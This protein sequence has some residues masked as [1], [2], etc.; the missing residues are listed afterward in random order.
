LIKEFNYVE[1]E[2]VDS[3]ISEE[4]KNMVREI[5]LHTKIEDFVDA[6]TFMNNL[7]KEL[8]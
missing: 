8:I 2:E 4:H 7:E 3:T 1:I 5:K 6:D